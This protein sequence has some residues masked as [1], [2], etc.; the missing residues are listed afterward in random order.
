L[1]AQ[2]LEHP[3]TI[4]AASVSPLPPVELASPV[5]NQRYLPIF[6]F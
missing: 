2:A 5:K 3:F 1:Q 4:A 6:S